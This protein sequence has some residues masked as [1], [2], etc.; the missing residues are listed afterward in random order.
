MRIDGGLVNFLSIEK[1]KIIE[2]T[3]R[4]KFTDILY[5]QE[6]L[7]CSHPFSK[8]FTL[9]KM[10]KN[11]K[12]DRIIQDNWSLPSSRNRYCQ[13]SCHRLIP[14]TNWC[15]NISARKKNFIT[16][17]STFELQVKFLMTALVFWTGLW[18]QNDFQ[19]KERLNLFN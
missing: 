16:A 11:R 8:N 10:T 17:L 3:F 14:I 6:K 13:V 7:S 15:T 5:A 12:M 4:S 19:G 1:K 18:N 2:K 9:S